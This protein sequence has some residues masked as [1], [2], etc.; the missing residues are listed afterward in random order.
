MPSHTPAAQDT[1]KK[2]RFTIVDVQFLTQKPEN[3]FQGD[4]VVNDRLR[5]D[6]LRKDIFRDVEPESCLEDILDYVEDNSGMLVGLMKVTCTGGEAEEVPASFKST[7][8]S[9][10]GFYPDGWVWEREVKVV[11]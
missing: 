3:D 2:I 7:I 9:L 10:S 4:P 5:N 11:K 1:T 6:W 8:P